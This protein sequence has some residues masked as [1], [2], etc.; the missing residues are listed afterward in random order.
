MDK[1][2]NMTALRDFRHAPNSDT[3]FSWVRKGDVYQVAPDRVSFHVQ[4]GR[5]EEI[6]QKKGK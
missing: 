2:V 6:K 4:S 5:G 1:L 3:S